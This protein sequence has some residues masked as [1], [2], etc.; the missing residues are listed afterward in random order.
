MAG[1]YELDRLLPAMGVACDVVA[2]SL[3]PKGSSDR[4]SLPDGVSGTERER[5]L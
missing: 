1:G 2:P 3:I 4:S 5:S